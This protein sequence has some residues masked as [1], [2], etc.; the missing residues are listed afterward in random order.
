MRRAGAERP[1]PRHLTADAG[2]EEVQDRRRRDHHER[3]AVAPADRGDD[4]GEQRGVAPPTVAGGE[5]G[6]PISHPSPAHGASNT[7]VREMYGSTY[8]DSM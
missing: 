7:D 2:V 5:H 6:N 1:P 4:Q 3:G 8:G